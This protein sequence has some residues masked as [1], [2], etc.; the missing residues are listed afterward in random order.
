[1]KQLWVFFFQKNCVTEKEKRIRQVTQ[2]VN[3]VVRCWGECSL[4]QYS[5]QLNNTF[6]EYS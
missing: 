3:E 2:D 5:A 4:V 1:M 6:C